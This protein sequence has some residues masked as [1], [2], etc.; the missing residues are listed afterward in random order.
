MAKSAVLGNCYCCIISALS[1][2]HAYHRLEPGP[3]QSAQPKLPSTIPTIIIKPQRL[4]FLFDAQNKPAKTNPVYQPLGFI[5]E[6]KSLRRCVPYPETGLLYA[7][8]IKTVSSRTALL[9]P[10]HHRNP[11][12]G[13][14]LRPPLWLYWNRRIGPHIGPLPPAPPKRRTPGRAN[15]WKIAFLDFA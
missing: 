8:T 13:T 14:F 10:D 12:N 9:Q 1:L 2:H 5:Y 7:K 15:G 4:P 3:C 6:Y 11:Q